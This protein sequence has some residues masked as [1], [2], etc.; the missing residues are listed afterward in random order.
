MDICR[1]CRLPAAGF[2]LL[3]WLRFI[4]RQLSPVFGFAVLFLILVALAGAFYVLWIWLFFEH[5]SEI[6]RKLTI[7]SSELRRKQS[8]FFDN[9]P[10]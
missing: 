2:A 7:R 8:Q 4:W 10:K 3:I 5:P 1:L 9:L 6:A